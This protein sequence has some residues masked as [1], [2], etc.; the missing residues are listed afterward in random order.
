MVSVGIQF[1]L[2]VTVSEGTDTSDDQG[3]LTFLVRGGDFGVGEYYLLKLR[4]GSFRVNSHC[5]DTF[6]MS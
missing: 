3:R 2:R 5:T 1:S 4:Y 6:R